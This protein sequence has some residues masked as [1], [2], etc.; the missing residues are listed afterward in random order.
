[1]LSERAAKI[2]LG[3]PVADWEDVEKLM[4][5]V[6]VIQ[7]EL[8]PI[9]QA[10]T[11]YRAFMKEGSEYF[12]IARDRI[13]AEDERREKEDARRER[14]MNWI[15]IWAGI[16]GPLFV[17]L[18]IWIAIQAYS[19]TM[20]MDKIDHAWHSELHHQSFF[21]QTDPARPHVNDAIIPPLSPTQ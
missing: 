1:M 17:A 7:A 5:D 15:K 21:N 8:V 6:A 9:K 19:F 16:A 11:N 3:E 20:D 12:T 18:I 14:R 10:V 13:K 4:I 2:I